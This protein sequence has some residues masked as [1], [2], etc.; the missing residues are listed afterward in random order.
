MKRESIRHF[1]ISIV[2]LAVAIIFYTRTDISI[3]KFLIFFIGGI[4]CGANLILGIFTFR[5]PK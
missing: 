1:T 5:K 3:A 2:F 4:A